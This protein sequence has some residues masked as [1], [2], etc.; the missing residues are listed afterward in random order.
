MVLRAEIA[1]AQAKRTRNLTAYDL[2]LQA[3]SLTMKRTGE[4]L[5]KALELL[6]EATGH[7]PNFAS[8]F[9][10][11]ATCHYNLVLFYGVPPEQQEAY[12]LK[13]ARRAIEIGQDNPEA[14]SRAAVVIAIVGEKP[15]EGRQHVERALALSPNLNLVVRDA[16]LICGL[17]GEHEL[18]IQRYKQVLRLNPTWLPNFDTFFG[19]AGICFFAGRFDESIEWADRALAEQPNSTPASALKAAS[20]SAANRA[21]DEIREMSRAIA[22]LPAEAFR[23]RLKG[24]RQTDVD[25]FIAALRKVDLLRD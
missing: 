14:L 18:A 1:R 6:Y 19:L 11:I 12:A 21:A 3:M 5:G 8:A 24:F 13:A 10:L 4:S 22:V 15:E 23:R 7:D 16:A 9:G 2:Y 17:Q 25:S 20:M